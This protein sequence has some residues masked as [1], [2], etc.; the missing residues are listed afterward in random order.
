[1]GSCDKN[2]WDFFINKKPKMYK[3]EKDDLAKSKLSM[4]FGGDP[5]LR[6]QWLRK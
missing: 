5:E 4:A 2:G 6:K 3:V 1:L